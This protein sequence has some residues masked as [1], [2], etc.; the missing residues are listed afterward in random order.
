M[1]LFVS[2]VMIH[3]TEIVISFTEG[4]E[5]MSEQRERRFFLFVL[6]FDGAPLRPLVIGN[7]QMG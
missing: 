6:W 1:S 5:G 7:T 4:I 3:V 2:V